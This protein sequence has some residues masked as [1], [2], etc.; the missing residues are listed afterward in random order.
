MLN[1]W[2]LLNEIYVEVL[3]TL[4]SFS[5]ICLDLHRNIYCLMH[6]LLGVREGF[7][8]LK[9][10]LKIYSPRCKT[11]AKNHF[12]IFKRHY[13]W[14]CPWVWQMVWFCLH[15]FLLILNISFNWIILQTKMLNFIYRRKILYI[16]IVW[17]TTKIL[18][19]VQME[20]RA[21][22]VSSW[23]TNKSLFSSNNLGAI[24]CIHQIVLQI[25]KVNE[26]FISFVC[27]KTGLNKR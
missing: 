17:Q 27:E 7:R 11:S 16:K 25:K 5:D 15:R 1:L 14:I 22:R 20:S 2:F 3:Q 26:L 12:C 9:K 24:T 18:S 8:L 23:G 6:I 13:P 10:R 19:M 21:W 4:K